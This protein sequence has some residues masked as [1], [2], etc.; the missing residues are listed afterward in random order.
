MKSS[1]KKSRLVGTIESEE[2]PV[3]S[4]PYSPIPQDSNSPSSVRIRVWWEPHAT[5]TAFAPYALKS[6]TNLFQ[7]FSISISKIS[8]HRC[9]YRGVDSDCLELC[10]N[11]PP[12]TMKLSHQNLTRHMNFK[13]HV[14]PF[15]H[16]PP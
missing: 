10:P 9:T 8:W 7:I 14:I 11:C 3:P 2:D 13:L 6:S 16:V 5:E 1:A 4:R 12:P 15:I